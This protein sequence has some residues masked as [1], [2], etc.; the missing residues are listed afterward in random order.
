MESA[1]TFITFEGGDGAGKTTQIALLAEALRQAGIDVLVTR[2]PGGCPEAEALRNLMLHRHDMEW[3]AMSLVLL[4]TA[5]RVE[6]VRKVIK[7]ALDTGKTVICD[8]FYDSTLAYQG[9]G[10]G[11]DL[12]AVRAVHMAALNGLQPDATFI[13]DI[14]PKDG[15]E[16]VRVRGVAADAIEKLDISFHQRLR[17]GF[18]KIAEAEPERITVINAM[19]TMEDMHVEICAKLAAKQGLPL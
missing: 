11:V 17:D 15:M 4:L 12:S 13:L 14:D 7:P 10:A 9:Y 6:H 1:G 18:L 2:E 3:D 16:R 5:A 8:R 19:Q